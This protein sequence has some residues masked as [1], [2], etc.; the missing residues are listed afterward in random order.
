MFTRGFL[1]MKATQEYAGKH[2]G[3]YLT[4]GKIA[5]SRAE[6][7]FIELCKHAEFPEATRLGKN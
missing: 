2:D 7:R 4:L 3:I 5:A 6:A 1:G